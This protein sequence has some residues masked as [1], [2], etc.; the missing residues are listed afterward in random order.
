MVPRGHQGA[1]RSGDFPCSQTHSSD[2]ALEGAAVSSMPTPG[3]PLRT[4]RGGKGTAGCGRGPGGGRRGGPVGEAGPVLSRAGRW[5][6]ALVSRA[7]G[8]EAS[9]PLGPAGGQPGRGLAMSRASGRRPECRAEKQGSAQ[10]RLLGCKVP[11]RPP[12]E[13]LQ[14]GWGSGEARALGRRGRHEGAPAAQ[15]LF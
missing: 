10:G 8:A 12:W 14:H 4:G 6:R 9:A 5:A 2:S 7:G 1:H 3:E 15:G 13:T 11:A